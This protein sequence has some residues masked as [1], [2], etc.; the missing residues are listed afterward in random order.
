MHA[1]LMQAYFGLF[2]EIEL[3]YP[4]LQ[5]MHAADLGPL[6]RLLD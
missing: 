2:G 5:H 3:A 1:V 4:I 6:R